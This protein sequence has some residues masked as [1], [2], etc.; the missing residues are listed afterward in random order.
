MWTVNISRD[1]GYVYV[2][3]LRWTHPIRYPMQ[4]ATFELIDCDGESELGMLQRAL[5]AAE[6]ELRHRQLDE[7]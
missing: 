4:L 1:G 7:Y 6:L 3:V 2:R 5:R